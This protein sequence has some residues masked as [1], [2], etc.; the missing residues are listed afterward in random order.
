[1]HS[2]EL[3]LDLVFR[4]GIG[5][6]FLGILPTYTEGK[7]GKDFS[8]LCL[9]W[10]RTHQRSQ[11]HPPHT[12]D[13]KSCVFSQKDD[14]DDVFKRGRASCSA[15]MIPIKTPPQKKTQHKTIIS[16]ALPLARPAPSCNPDTE[17]IVCLLSEMTHNDPAAMMY[18]RENKHILHKWYTKIAK[19]M[20][21]EGNHHLIVRHR[22]LLPTFEDENDKDSEA[23]IDVGV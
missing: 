2:L 3:H 5:Q 4:F 23:N 20:M 6:Y 17:K 9:W 21:H 16:F 11:L 10:E 19:E 12:I 15:N 8:V 18:C 1:V 13:K 14:H 22:A 7:L